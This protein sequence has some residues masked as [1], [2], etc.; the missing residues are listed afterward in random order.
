MKLM[1]PADINSPKSLDKDAGS[2]PSLAAMLQTLNADVR[3]LLWLDFWQVKPFV[4]DQ[5]T[6]TIRLY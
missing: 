5:S 6:Y 1:Q 4:S 3:P 2:S